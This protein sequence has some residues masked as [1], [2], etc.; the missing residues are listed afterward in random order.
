MTN[1]DEGRSISGVELTT[2]VDYKGVPRRVLPRQSVFHLPDG[3][4]HAS[5]GGPSMC[6]THLIKTTACEAFLLSKINFPAIF[7][8]MMSQEYTDLPSGG[9]NAVR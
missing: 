5:H 7:V 9:G 3:A 4:G 2:H 8:M 6:N 1:S